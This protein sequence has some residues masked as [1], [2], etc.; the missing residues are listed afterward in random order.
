MARSGEASMAQQRSVALLRD[1]AA[2]ALRE[3]AISGHGLPALRGRL[4][5]NRSQDTGADHPT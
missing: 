5:A 3:A 2:P 1:R 4:A